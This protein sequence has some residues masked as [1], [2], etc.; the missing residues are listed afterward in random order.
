MSSETPMS[1]AERSNA[2]PPSEARPLEAANRRLRGQPGRPRTRPARAPA[3]TVDVSIVRPL[4][5]RLLD[6][7]G[8]AAYLSVSPDVIRDLD[9]RGALRRVRL[10]GAAGADL[11]RVLFDVRDLDAL[12]D[13]SRDA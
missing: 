3:V 13:R 10:P 6:V 12:V 1:S 8:A 11:R 4:H 9:A 2:S 7:M 5:P